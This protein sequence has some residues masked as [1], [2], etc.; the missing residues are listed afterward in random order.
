MEHP[1]DREFRKDYEQA[2]L[3]GATTDSIAGWMNANAKKGIQTK[4]AG[5]LEK[6][7]ALEAVKPIYGEIIK[8]ISK[9]RADIEKLKEQPEKLVANQR[10]ELNERFDD[11][12]GNE[13]YDE[14]NRAL[15]VAGEMNKFLRSDEYQ[16]AKNALKD[17]TNLYSKSL[18]LKEEWE[19]E[20]A[21]IIEAE[22]A[23]SRREELLSADPEALR[24]LGITPP[25]VQK[26]SKAEED[27]ELKER[28]E[29]LRSIHPSA[30]EA[31][32]ESMAK[33]V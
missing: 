20:N 30:T 29:A 12:V 28:M 27:P 21:D 8:T 15:W 6:R 14:S 13:L 1:K 5:R 22:R 26:V 2:V 19:Q 23:R 4:L 24:A 16:N 31:E 10:K 11:L 33:Q 17:A 25:P 3:S 7:I 18:A 9:A 32:L